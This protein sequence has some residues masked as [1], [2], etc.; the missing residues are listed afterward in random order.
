MYT[1]IK[2]SCKCNL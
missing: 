2:D 1:I